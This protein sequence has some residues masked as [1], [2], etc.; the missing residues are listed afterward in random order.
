MA[1][2]NHNRL[3]VKG[4]TA[5]LKKFYEAFRGHLAYYWITEEHF[6]PYPMGLYPMEMG[7]PALPGETCKQFN[8][9]MEESAAQK[10]K[11]ICF[12]A[13]Y[14]VPEDIRKLGY[15][16]DKMNTFR[17]GDKAVDGWSW[18]NRH[19]GTK[20]EMLEPIIHEESDTHGIYEFD[21]A[22]YCPIPWLE[23]VSRMFPKLRFEIAYESPG[24]SGP[25]GISVYVDGR[26]KLETKERD[27]ESINYFILYAHIFKHCKDGKFG[28]ETLQD[29]IEG[30]AIDEDLDWFVDF[31]NEIKSTTADDVECFIPSSPSNIKIINT[32]L[33]DVRNA[34]AAAVVSVF[35]KKEEGMQKTKNKIDIIKKNL[36]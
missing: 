29:K 35:K 18:Q 12:N 25:I 1:D 21:T 11:T 22:W 30:I 2:M 26:L 33:D 13:L 20:W 4:P 6:R 5:E 34:F 14:P 8:L 23:H 16:C 7:G 28:N 3:Y 17:I 24:I 31:Y 9:R 10:P 19:W 32:Y 27:C 15:S 36:K